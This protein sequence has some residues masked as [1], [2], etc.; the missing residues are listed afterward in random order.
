MTITTIIFDFGGVLYKMPDSKGINKWLHLLGI[1]DN[2]VITEMLAN[3]HESKLVKDICLGKI[4]EEHAWGM[5]GT[6]WSVN[7]AL[8]QRIKRNYFSKRYLNRRIVRFMAALK[9]DFKLCILSNAGDQSRSLMTDVLHL[10]RFVD[11]II[12]SAEEG[13]I[14]PDPRIYQIAMDR[15]NT[16]PE[17]TLFIDDY[18]E[19]IKA[20]ERFGMKAIRFIDN[21]H[22]LQMISNM[23]REE[24]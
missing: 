22:T 12:I 15:L 2:P 5:I 23:I 14:K 16:T 6:K 17:H 4:P 11:E 18:L 20:A 24:G 10:D 3:P 13:I 9:D 7:P 21:Q 19:N 1:K 8:I